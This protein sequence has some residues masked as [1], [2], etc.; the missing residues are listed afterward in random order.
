MNWF[1]RRGFEAVTIEDFTTSRL[2]PS[3]ALP[4]ALLKRNCLPGGREVPTS[5]SSAGSTT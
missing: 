3:A 5:A 2:S 1:L 4:A